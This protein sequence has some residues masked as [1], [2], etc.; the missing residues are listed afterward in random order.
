MR[1]VLAM[2]D[3]RRWA[4]VNQNHAQTDQDKCRD[5]IGTYDFAQ[6]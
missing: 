5:E 3:L 6:N 1:T 4:I 2:A